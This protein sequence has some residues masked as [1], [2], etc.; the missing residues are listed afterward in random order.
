MT[1]FETKVMEHLR[2]GRYELLDRYK[3]GLTQKEIKKIFRESFF[4]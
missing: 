3:E 4:L 1:L 2:S